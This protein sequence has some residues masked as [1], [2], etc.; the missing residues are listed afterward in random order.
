MSAALSQS[1]ATLKRR[2][3]SAQVNLAMSDARW[4]AFAAEPPLPQV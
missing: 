2:L 1:D 4:L 3:P